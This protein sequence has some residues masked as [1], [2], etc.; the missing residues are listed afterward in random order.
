MLLCCLVAL[1]F[2]F[3]AFLFTSSCLLTKRAV[4]SLFFLNFVDR[5]ENFPYHLPLFI[6]DIAFQCLLLLEQPHKPCAVCPNFTLANYISHGHRSWSVFRF[7]A[8]SIKGS[9]HFLSRF[10]KL[11][12]LNLHRITAAVGE[13]I[14]HYEIFTGP[15]KKTSID[16]KFL[17][18]LDR[19]R[20]AS[21]R[22]IHPQK[23]AKISMAFSSAVM[24]MHIPEKSFYTKLPP[25]KKT[26]NSHFIFQ[27]Y[28]SYKGEFAWHTFRATLSAR[29]AAWSPC[30]GNCRTSKVCCK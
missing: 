4:F 19:Q 29:N 9:Y 23:H 22:I 10:G 14:W 6:A 21:L 11:S 20:C 3:T 30:F 1:P 16:Q 12:N 28:P 5:A 18:K 25:K 24:N 17:K 7:Y 13:Y 2:A 26:G 15:T 27:R 8:G